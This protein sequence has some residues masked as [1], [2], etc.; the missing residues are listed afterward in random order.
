MN[1]R[2]AKGG[3]LELNI[4]GSHLKRAVCIHHTK[5]VKPHV[6]LQQMNPSNFS[7]LFKKLT[8]YRCYAM[9]KPFMFEECHLFRIPSTVWFHQDFLLSFICIL[10][11]IYIFS[12]FSFANLWPKYSFSLLTWLKLFLEKYVPLAHQGQHTMQRLLY[13]LGTFEYKKHLFTIE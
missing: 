2:F 3:A 12:S 5:L 11:F 10:T 9:Q 1:G 7:H 8:I 6:L 4:R 13:Y